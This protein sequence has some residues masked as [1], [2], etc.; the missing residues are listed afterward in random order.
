MLRYQAWGWAE[1]LRV[2]RSFISECVS[3]K[4]RK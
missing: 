1:F 4:V 2:I 3:M